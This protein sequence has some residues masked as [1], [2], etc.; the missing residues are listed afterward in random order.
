MDLQINGSVVT[1]TYVSAVSDTGGPT[2]SFPVSGSVAGDLISFSV[3]WSGA[4]TAWVGHGVFAAGAPQILTL[5]HLVQTV[6]DETDPS[7]KWQTVFAGADE[8]TR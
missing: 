6:D 4:I 2:P 1:G 8:F 5:W 7:K 3:N